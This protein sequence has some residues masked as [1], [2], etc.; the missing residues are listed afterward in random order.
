VNSPLACAWTNHAT[1]RL[2]ER[3]GSKSVNV[4][5]AIEDMIARE[6]FTVIEDTQPREGKIVIRLNVRECPIELAMQLDPRG[7]PVIIT[8]LPKFLQKQNKRKWAR[9]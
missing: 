5:L 2:G 6:E 1:A 4:K 7:I 9:Q 8:V 3:F